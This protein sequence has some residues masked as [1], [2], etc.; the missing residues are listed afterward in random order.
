MG[1][2]HA[3]RN[4]GHPAVLGGAAVLVVLVSGVSGYTYVTPDPPA[5]RSERPALLIPAAAAGQFSTSAAEAAR[6]A[7]VRTKRP[8]PAGSPSAPGRGLTPSR[9]SKPSARPV[10]KPSLVHAAVVASPTPAPHPS[11]SAVPSSPACEWRWHQ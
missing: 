4:Y 11:P 1:R 8:R 7:A 2:H 9:T 5:V 10:P 6:P 3:R